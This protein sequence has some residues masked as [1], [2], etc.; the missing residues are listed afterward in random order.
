MVAVLI[1]L[2]DLGSDRLLKG[3]L[4][5]A[6]FS[7]C[8]VSFRFGLCCSSIEFHACRFIPSSRATPFFLSAPAGVNDQHGRGCALDGPVLTTNTVYL[9]VFWKG[10]C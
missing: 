6:V 5:L 8:V 3:E 9:F 2:H 1:N 4:V 7:F 10:R